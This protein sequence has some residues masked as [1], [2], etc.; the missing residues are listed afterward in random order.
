MTST[1]PSRVMDVREILR[2]NP[3]QHCVYAGQYAS[4]CGNVVV[5]RPSTA[6]RAATS[7]EDVSVDAD[8]ILK[9]VSEKIDAIE[10][11]PGAAIKLGGA[12][13]AVVIANSIVTSIEAIPL[14]PKLLE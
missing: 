5:L 10:D 13:V 11:K 9:G 3:V 14:L 12:L 6:V 7:K 2:S 1:V 4:L 8:E